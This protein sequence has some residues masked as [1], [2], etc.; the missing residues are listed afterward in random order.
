MYLNNNDCSRRI[1]HSS[2]YKQIQQLMIETKESPCLFRL[3]KNSRRKV[4]QFEISNFLTRPNLSLSPIPRSTGCSTAGGINEHGTEKCFCAPERTT[5]ND[6]R[7]IL[8]MFPN[9]NK[10]ND[11]ITT[12]HEVNDL[13]FCPGENTSQT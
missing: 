4:K 7:T 13:F 9:C 10:N 6:C 8:K 11:R 5:M 3:C 12:A 2:E 1:V